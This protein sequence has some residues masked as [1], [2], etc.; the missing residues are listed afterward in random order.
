[1]TI[2]DAPKSRLQTVVGGLYLLVAVFFF[3]Y[4]LNYFVTGLGGPTLL[5][6]TMVPVTF[7]LFTLDS[8]RR[9]AL[10]PTLGP[11]AN[12]VIAAVYCAFSIAVAIYMHE[13]GRALV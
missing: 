10:Y 4:L 7:V 13:I 5:A 2:I 9:D 8:L 12:C 3:F 11:A 6:A 1:M